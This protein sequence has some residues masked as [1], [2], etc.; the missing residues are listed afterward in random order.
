MVVMVMA[1]GAR[2]PVEFVQL[3]DGADLLFLLHPSVLE[4]DF[5]LSLGEVERHGQLHAPAPR[6]VAT[7]V[8]LFLQLQRLVT[9]VRLATAAPL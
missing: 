2:F 1:H 6:Q 7:V 9:R 4:P 8:E 5:H 3:L